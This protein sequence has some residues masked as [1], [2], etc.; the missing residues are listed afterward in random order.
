MST[1][2][3]F[4]Q[5]RVLANLCSWPVSACREGPFSVGRKPSSEMLWYPNF[6]KSAPAPG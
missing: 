3:C 1:M 2:G 4:A 5:K 6:S